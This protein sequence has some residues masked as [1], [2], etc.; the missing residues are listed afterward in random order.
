MSLVKRLRIVSWLAVVLVF[1]GF[2]FALLVRGC[3][4]YWWFRE[5]GQQE[6]YLVVAKAR[7]FCAFA[8]GLFSL[9]ALWSHFRGRTHI[10]PSIVVVMIVLMFAGGAASMWEK[11]LLVDQSVP[12]GYHGAFGVDASFDVFV[13][14][15][16]QVLMRWVFWLLLL[17][18]IGDRIMALDGL[19]AG[20]PEMQKLRAAAMLIVMVVLMSASNWYGLPQL[21]DSDRMTAYGYNLGRIRSSQP[22]STHLKASP[23]SPDH[24]SLWDKDMILERLNAAYGKDLRSEY[25][26]G[27]VSPSDPSLWQCLLEPAAPDQA[28]IM[29]TKQGPVVAEGYT[30]RM[31]LVKADSPQLNIQNIDIN[32]VWYSQNTVEPVLANSVDRQ[33]LIL[34]GATGYYRGVIY[35]SQRVDPQAGY[36]LGSGLRRL[37]ISLRVG[38]RRL[39]SK[40]LSNHSRI[41]LRRSIYDRMRAVAPFLMYDRTIDIVR[42]GNSIVWQR[43]AYL[44]V[45]SMPGSKQTIIN[46]PSGMFY[47]FRSVKPGVLIQ[48]DGN[49]GKVRFIAAD[50]RNPLLDTYRRVFPS[51]FLDGPSDLPVIGSDYLSILA[52][53]QGWAL[54]VVDRPA[55]EQPAVVPIRTI[56]LPSTK[57]IEPWRTTCNGYWLSLLP[58]QMS[59]TDTRIRG[60]L[61]SDAINIWRVDFA[62]PQ[63][64]STEFVK[65]ANKTAGELRRGEIRPCVISGKLYWLRS[66]YS[67]NGNK[68]QLVK[69]QIGRDGKLAEGIKISAVINQLR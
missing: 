52:L 36:E 59:A 38:E 29:P 19:T 12:F 49:T 56:P 46:L 15:L 55:S 25:V 26:S 67:G 69:I 10:V 54:P 11:V 68:L 42:E 66:L 27:S 43:T 6:A 22:D 62:K 50:G 30:R 7:A 9:V 1:A 61:A 48:L 39:L 13:L 65:I 53:V 33:Q 58:Y 51:M 8:G 37:L 16:L 5:L 3:T 41:L 64:G 34:T 23:C 32:P 4:E 47:Q 2:M 63:M 14:P 57:Q 31:S 44:G 60:Y 17:C 45:D 40:S 24:I 18:F 20:S 28:N 35:S 21:S